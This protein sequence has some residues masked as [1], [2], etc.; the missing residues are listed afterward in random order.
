MLT[1][2]MVRRPGGTVPLIGTAESTSTLSGILFSRLLGNT[3]ILI[4]RNQRVNFVSFFIT[5]FYWRRVGKVTVT[6]KELNYTA[7]SIYQRVM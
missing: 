3:Y 1:V 6:E 5:S 7:F 4:Q 2:A